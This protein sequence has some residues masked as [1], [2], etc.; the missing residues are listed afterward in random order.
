MGSGGVCP[1]IGLAMHQCHPRHTPIALPMVPTVP[2][3]G[4]VHH[5][6]EAPM[7]SRRLI[8]VVEKY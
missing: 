7:G 1:V 5:R 8:P 2:R 6:R 4:T 3:Q